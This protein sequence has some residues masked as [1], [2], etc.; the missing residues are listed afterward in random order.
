MATTRRT[1]RARELGGATQPNGTQSTYVHADD[2]GVL[3]IAGT[4]ISLDSVVIAFQ[5]GHS[6]ES[7]RQ[8]YP[9]LTLEAVYG[10]LTYYLANR[11]TV[12]E[13]LLHQ[14]Q[15]WA[16]ARRE[17]DSHPSPVVERL[18]VLLRNE[19]AATT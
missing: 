15:V 12:D 2:H 7:I 17:S 5:E 13:Y 4:R 18:R 16:E 10:A 19:A 6:P 8:Q 11:E 14:E 3:R 9:A 1:A